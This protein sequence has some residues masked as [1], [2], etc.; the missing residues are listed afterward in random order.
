MQQNH[1]PYALAHEHVLC[2]DL[3]QLRSELARIEALGG[4]GLMLRQPGSKYEVGRSITLIKVK[5][6]LDSEARVAG[7]EPGKGRHNGRLGALL[8][9]L[10]DGTQFSVGTGFSDAERGTPPPI[11]S[12]ITF[13]Y[14]EL[15]DGGVPRFPSYLGIRR[16]SPIASIPTPTEK[17]EI[18]V[19]SIIGKRRFEYVVG[20]SDKFWEIEVSGKEV[21]VRFG[22]NGTH[23]QSSTKSFA[24]EAAVQKHAEKLIE[25]KTAKG[26]VEVG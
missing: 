25:E 12:T 15:T 3:D 6:F 26:Y 19:P 24:D 8:V 5:S 7:H 9:E 16:D 10:A 4:E 13:R 14:Q 18:T 1:P 23:G 2:T 21:I 20:S 17:G 22:R 11:G